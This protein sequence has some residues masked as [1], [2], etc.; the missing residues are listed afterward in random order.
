MST[1]AL[2]ASAGLLAAVLVVPLLIQ[3][4]A[5]FEEQVRAVT[6]RNS[7][8]QTVRLFYGRHSPLQA[9][10]MTTLGPYMQSVEPLLPGDMVW[11]LDANAEELDR[12]IV[13]YDVVAITVDPSCLRLHPTR[14]R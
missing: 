4:Q 14:V 7:C 12:S 13:D 8:P 2:L 11:L 10:N 1:R 6:I 9:Q 3:A 5:P